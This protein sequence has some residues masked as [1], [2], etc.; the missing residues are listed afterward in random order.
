MR[1][2]AEA[3]RFTRF[4]LVRGSNGNYSNSRRCRPSAG[5]RHAARRPGY[6]LTVTDL[7]TVSLLTV[8]DTVRRTVKVV[9]VVIE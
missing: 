8:E 6:G 7:V 3:T 5:P 2:A 9:V 4:L 1:G